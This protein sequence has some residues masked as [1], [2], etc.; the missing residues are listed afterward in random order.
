L[1]VEISKTGCNRL[2]NPLAI[3]SPRTLLI[4][5]TMCPTV[6]SSGSRTYLKICRLRHL[7]TVEVKK[8]TCRGSKFQDKKRKLSGIKDVTVK[9]ARMGPILAP[10]PP[11]IL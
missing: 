8:M 3:F 1:F 9:P 5:L 11:A 6:T 10:T 2:L 7:K 4:V